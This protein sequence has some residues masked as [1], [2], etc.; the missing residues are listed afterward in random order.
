MS[1][2]GPSD[3]GPDPRL[4]V[5]ADITE[6]TDVEVDRLLEARLSRPDERAREASTSTEVT[7][8]QAAR[9]RAGEQEHLMARD[10]RSPAWSRYT[11]PSRDEV[12]RVS[13]K[14]PPVT[15]R[16][17]TTPLPSEVD[18]LVLGAIPEGWA[19]ATSPTDLEVAA[20]CARRAELLEDGRSGWRPWQLPTLA[21]GTLA[22]AAAVAALTVAVW[23]VPSSYG[24]P[25]LLPG[26]TASLSRDEVIDLGPSIDLTP[27]ALDNAAGP[28][29]VHIA[30][31]D[32]EGTV[33]D[34]LEGGTWFEV[35]PKGLHRNL[36]VR[37]GDVAVTVK[38][39]V[40]TVDHIDDQVVVA[41]ERG[42]VQVSTAERTFFLNTGERWSSTGSETASRRPELAPQP[43]VASM[44]PPPHVPPEPEAM[45]RTA[46]RPSPEARRPAIPEP[47]PPPPV[48][49]EPERVLKPVV[50]A[51]PPELLPKDEAPP[52]NGKDD[53]ART[54][55]DLD[56]LLILSRRAE[57][58][59]PVREV[60][61]DVR[62]FLQANPDERLRKMAHRI[63]L[64]LL[65][66]A[67]DLVAF[68]EALQARLA[69]D[70][71]NAPLHQQRADTQRALG[72]C[73]TAL[74]HYQQASRAQ[75]PVG[76]R[77]LGGMSECFLL[78]GRQEE[79]REALRTAL[80]RPL[81]PAT[82]EVIMDRLQR[83]EK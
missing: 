64:S 24:T 62:D 3:D 2:N 1:V 32:T 77:A 42:R 57:S 63:E 5:L 53:T 72:D 40:F 51:P 4:Q 44:N 25:D 58:N 6:P 11:A 37:A 43:V 73:N 79:A 23:P 80:K 20:L 28:A 66:Q 12:E 33:V 54:A 14:A 81:D 21:L 56:A 7:W 75:T 30:Q 70:P 69:E 48:L 29:K 15:I 41:V 35:D 45:V 67:G 52:E 47:A 17:H 34:V 31:A 78:L 9:V 46:P 10:P 82:E 38:G 39:T 65:R 13:P 8:A 74:L 71:Q 59:E 68:D 16:L 55:A 76:V 36:T 18:R 61:A 83:M 60:L 49:H 19:A 50:V 26:T 22:G 27:H